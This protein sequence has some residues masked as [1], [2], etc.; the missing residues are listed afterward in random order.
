VVISGY[1][2]GQGSIEQ[3]GV[4]KTLPNPQY[5]STVRALMTR[6]KCDQY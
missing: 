3:D 2:A 1:N 5:V 6:C 4:N